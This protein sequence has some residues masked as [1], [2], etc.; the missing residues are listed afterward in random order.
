MSKQTAGCV[1]TSRE[2]SPGRSHS[3]WRCIGE[4]HPYASKEQSDL[5]CKKFI[6]FG[7]SPASIA[8][9]ST[10]VIGPRITT[11]VMQICDGLEMMQ[12]ISAKPL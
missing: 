1:R 2:S 5:S 11:S 3:T 8:S 4:S 9:T 10:A 6:H 12:T 7:M